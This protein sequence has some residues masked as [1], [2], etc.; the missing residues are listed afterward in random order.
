MA[1]AAIFLG[2]IEGNCLLTITYACSAVVSKQGDF[3]SIEN[4]AKW[5]Y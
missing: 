4:A 1:V 2:S 3:V 5:L